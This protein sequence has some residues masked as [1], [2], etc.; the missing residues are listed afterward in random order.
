E[1]VKFAQ[2][3]PDLKSPR[4]WHRLIQRFAGIKCAYPRWHISH[5]R[6]TCP[7]SGPVNNAPPNSHRLVD[8]TQSPPPSPPPPPMRTVRARFIAPAHPT[9]PASFL[10]SIHLTW[11]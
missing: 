2:V 5:R 7:T 9:P 8:L 4:C 10:S 6:S 1:L 11:R 3:A